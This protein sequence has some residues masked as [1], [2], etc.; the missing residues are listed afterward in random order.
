MIQRSRSGDHPPRRRRATGAATPGGARLRAIRE[1]AGRAQLWVEAEADLG[2]GYLQRVESGRVAQP[3]RVTVERILAVLDA[4]YSEQREVLELFGYVVATPLPTEADFAWAR[5]SCQHE[6]HDVPFPA[7]VMD[8]VPRLIAWNGYV[9]RLLGL[10]GPAGEALL[11]RCVGEPLFPLWFDPSAPFGR[12]V[13]E[14]EVFI[15]GMVRALRYEY[16]RFQPEPWIAETLQEMT[17]RLPRFREVWEQATQLP[18]PISAAR[19]LLPV[20]L[21]VPAAGRLL[22][23]LV[24]EPFV[25]DTRFRLIYFVPAD[26]PTL[27]QCA[28]WASGS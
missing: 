17:A 26:A 10:S 1:Q 14:P 23:R 7:Y 16:S 27:R 22:F 2:T 15:P 4:R 11:Q 24:S 18:A 20:K 19:V 9:P 5:D 12:L 3:S 28:A 8:C 13:A 21:D 25:R 6:L